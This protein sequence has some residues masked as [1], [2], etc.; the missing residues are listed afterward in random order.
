MLGLGRLL[1]EAGNPSS[2]R[3]IRM[4]EQ[5]KLTPERLMQAKTF[6][7]D[8]VITKDQFIEM[9]HGQADPLEENESQELAK[10]FDKI[11]TIEQRLM[12]I[13]TALEQL[14]QAICSQD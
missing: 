2:E 7:D 14:T 8:G 4:T 6:L 9:T 5:K 13:E 10:I 3:V 12:R 1:I 11:N